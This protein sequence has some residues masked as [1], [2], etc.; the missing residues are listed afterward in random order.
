MS[1]GR[2]Y[3]QHAGRPPH[4]KY[5]LPTSGAARTFAGVVFRPY[6]RGI[7]MYSIVSDDFRIE[8]YSTDK[9]YRTIVDGEG[10]G[11]KFRS[12]RNAC[13]AGVKAAQKKEKAVG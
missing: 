4:P 13:E 8:V 6:R 1:E 7:L 10:L 3:P 2:V 9:T 5:G 12:E 11:T